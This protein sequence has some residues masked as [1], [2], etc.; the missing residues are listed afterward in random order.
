M[1][2]FDF[3]VLMAAASAAGSLGGPLD[4]AEAGLV[5]CYEPNDA[6]KTCRSMASYSKNPDGTWDNTAVV[7]LSPGQP[8]S[9]E[10]VT[11]VRIEDGAVCGYIRRD[12]VL[13]GKL[14]LSGKLIP[15]DKARPI[16][17]KIADGMSPLMGKEICTKYVRINNELVAKGAVEGGNDPVP[18]QRVKW[19]KPTD[20][21]SV[22]AG[23]A[24]AVATESGG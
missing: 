15:G 17:E 3:L 1:L 23:S 8:V 10:T 18:D 19:V 22:A 5:Q 7:E 24:Q 2:G 13:K 4:D 21:Y 16:L 20:G 12:D 9:L 6:A 14:R 11:P